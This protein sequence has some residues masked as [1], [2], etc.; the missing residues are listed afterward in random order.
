MKYVLWRK[1][2]LKDFLIGFKWEWIIHVIKAY[3][4][5]DLYFVYVVDAYFI[6]NWKIL[7]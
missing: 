3:S 1:Y 7:V 2:F 4:S 6:L 5:H